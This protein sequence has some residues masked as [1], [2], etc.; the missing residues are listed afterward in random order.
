MGLERQNFYTIKLKKNLAL[1]LLL[2]AY[3]RIIIRL[4]PLQ[5]DSAVSPMT[6][7]VKKI[8]LCG[9]YDANAT[10]T[11]AAAAVGVEIVVATSQ[12]DGDIVVVRVEGGGTRAPAEREL[13]PR[14]E[15]AQRCGGME[16]KKTHTYTLLSSPKG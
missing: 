11:T 9:C 15:T 8:M 1:S 14:T 13:R 5:H 4:R 12:V 2:W 7:G 16:R 6:M 3:L 10:A